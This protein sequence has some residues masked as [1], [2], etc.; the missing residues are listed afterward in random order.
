MNK[1]TQVQ[2]S[3]IKSQSFK[4]D[5]VFINLME[6]PNLLNQEYKFTTGS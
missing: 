3:N 1:D 5:D 4:L 6:V 2:I